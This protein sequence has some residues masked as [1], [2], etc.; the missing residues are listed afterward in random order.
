MQIYFINIHFWVVL[1]TVLL[2]PAVFS[3][4]IVKAKTWSD[5]PVTTLPEI[6]RE[7]MLA[8][9][10]RKIRNIA[11]TN[12]EGLRKVI[13]SGAD[14]NN[15]YWGTRP[16]LLAAAM[17]KESHIEFIK[18]LLEAGADPD[19]NARTR[20]EHPLWWAEL[21][22]KRELIKLLLNADAKV[23]MRHAIEKGY[24]EKVTELLKSGANPNANDDTGRSLLSLAE[25]KRRREI[26]LILVDAG[27]TM[28]LTHAVK[29]LYTKKVIEMLNAGAD[30]NEGSPLAVA[31]SKGHTDMVVLLLNSGA[32]VKDDG[33]NL[34][35][36]VQKNQPAIV[37]LLLRAGAK[38]DFEIP[39]EKITHAVELRFNSLLSLRTVP[40]N[41][42]QTEEYTIT[43]SE[44]LSLLHLAAVKGYSEIVSQ[45][46]NAGLDVDKSTND[47]Y[48]PLHC[49]ALF[50]H[51]DIVVML[52]K[53]EANTD[54]KVYFK[55]SRHTA[56]E[57]A[58]V[59]NHSD[60]VELIEEND[61]ILV[62]IINS[63]TDLF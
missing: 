45:L 2:P 46:I 63:V 16:I 40:R 6:D 18:I 19:G 48:T 35:K 38:F 31:V 51:I 17:S 15:I 44:G 43:N 42:K 33:S 13:A 21:N 25:S 12:I 59:K 1:L 41:E 57:L 20:G 56:E 53:E 5:R 58:R 28:T 49:A 37:A 39:K 24:S 26:A 29:H 34:I 10:K 7:A 27:A 36:A 14:V 62:K 61:S 47:D 22:R 8:E 11:L 30:P 32:N 23:T 54:P 50:G 9:E 4:E 3:E 55:G 52:L 60:I